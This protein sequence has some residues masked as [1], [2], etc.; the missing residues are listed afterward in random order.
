MQ[1]VGEPGS[2]GKQDEDNSVMRKEPTVAIE[3]VPTKS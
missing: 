1:A 3:E 2:K